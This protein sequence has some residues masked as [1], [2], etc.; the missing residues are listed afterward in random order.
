MCDKW[1]DE[2]CGFA[3]SDKRRRSCDNGLR[4][5]YSHAPEEERSEF[6]N[7]PL[8]DVEVIQQL[9]KGDEKDNG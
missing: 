8:D 6:Y 1:L 3:L 2:H 5:G 4:A 9:D 7:E